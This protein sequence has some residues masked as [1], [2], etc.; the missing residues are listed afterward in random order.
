MPGR[1]KEDARH[2]PPHPAR[3]QLRAL[4]HRQ[5]GLELRHLVPGHRAIT[6]GLP[7]DREHVSRRPDQLRD[8]RR[9]HHSRTVGRCRCR[10]LRPPHAP[11]PD[12]GGRGARE[13]GPRAPHRRGVGNRPGR[14]RN[15]APARLHNRVCDAGDA[16]HRAGPRVTRGPR[17]RG[18][19]EFR[20]VQSL[21]RH[22]R[23]ARRARARAVRRGHGDRFRM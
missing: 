3:A 5:P 12:P 9:R 18:R 13:R 15:G 2:I 1:Y 11:D 6:V 7:P 4:L 17:R 10:P 23:P 21:A 19:D 20:D 22:W 8:V 16:G 14:D